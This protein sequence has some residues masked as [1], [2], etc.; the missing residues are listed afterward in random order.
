MRSEV[1]WCVYIGWEVA[2]DLWVGN[3]QEIAKVG[4]RNAD[5]CCFCLCA[6]FNKVSGEEGGEGYGEASLHCKVDAT[7]PTG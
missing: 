3:G 5:C 6:E 1:E 2:T 4:L 7:R